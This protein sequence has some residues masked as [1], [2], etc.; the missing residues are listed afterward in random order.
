MFVVNGTVVGTWVALIPGI[1][2]RL[3]LPA[4]Q[5]GIILFFAAFGA[6]FGQQITGQLLV[7]VS[8]RVLLTAGGLLLPAMVVL[9]TLA[10]SPASLA[11][12]LF[13]FGML[14]TTMDVAMNAHGVALETSGGTSILSRLHSGW[15]VGGILGAVGVAVALLLGV[16]PTVEA[17]VAA[18]L[19]LGVAATA[20]RFLGQGSVRTEGAR[21]IHLPGR[22]VLPLGLLMVLVAFVEGGLTDW[23]GVYLRQGVQASAGVAALAFAAFSLGL[24]IGRIGGDWAKDRIGSVR[25]LQ[26]GMVLTAVAVAAFLVVG[27]DVVALAGMVVAGIGMANAIPQLLGA[28]ARIPPYGPSLSAVFTL[29]TVAFMAGPPL[30]G[31]TTEAFGITIAFGL[32]VVASLAVVILVPRVPAA[33]T[34]DRFRR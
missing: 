25:L 1:Q 6:L 17:L 16:E 20:S 32:F 21:G 31:A 14:N 2:E 19:M 5:L 3:A 28:A 22:A 29:L 18:A 33:E 15:S 27:S 26:V 13:F 24:F 8:S 9:P 12:V 23:G 34:S 7:R 11:V 10:P 4:D 30:I